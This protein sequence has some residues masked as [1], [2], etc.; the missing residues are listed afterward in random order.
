MEVLRRVVAAGE[1]EL[2]TGDGD[3][4]DQ[5]M[6]KVWS[7]ALVVIVVGEVAY[8]CM[9]WCLAALLRKKRKKIQLG[10]SVVRRGETK[11]CL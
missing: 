5:D 4:D 3:V 7:T 2:Y 11:V 9:W 1:I 8:S 10:A 6:V